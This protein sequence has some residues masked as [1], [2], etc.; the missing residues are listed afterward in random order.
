M[1]PTCIQMGLLH[2]LLE[3][4]RMLC[5]TWAFY[6]FRICSAHTRLLVPNYKTN[7]ITVHVYNY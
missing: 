3:H 4:T 1:R 5:H 2:S 6:C 7:N